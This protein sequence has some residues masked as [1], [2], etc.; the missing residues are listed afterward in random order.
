MYLAALRKA[1]NL[2]MEMHKQRL[3]VSDLC[4]A[5]PAK[6]E[7]ALIDGLEQTRMHYFYRR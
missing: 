3:E 7:A 4:R 1:I 2:E 6:R 5:A